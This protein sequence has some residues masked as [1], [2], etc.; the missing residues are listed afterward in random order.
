MKLLLKHLVVLSI[1]VVLHNYAFSQSQFTG[2]ATAETQEHQYI[3]AIYGEE[4]MNNNPEVVKELKVYILERVAYLQEPLTADDKYPLLSSFP[5]MNKNNPEIVAID[6][7]AFDPNTFN[8]LSYS[9]PFFSPLTNV[10]RVD[11]T[12]YIIV[13]Q[14]AN[15]H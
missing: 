12:D 10:I 5:L 13:I 8:P 1:G 7:A 15:Q 9:L 6:Y 3:A 14:P 4:W 11:N 2:Q